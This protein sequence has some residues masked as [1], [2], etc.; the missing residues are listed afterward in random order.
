M[1]SIQDNITDYYI[2]KIKS[3]LIDHYCILYKNMA[4]SDIALWDNCNYITR[5][6]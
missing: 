1:I 4:N 3:K 6:Y 2:L 5:L